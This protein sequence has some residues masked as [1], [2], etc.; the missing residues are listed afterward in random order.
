MPRI[1]NPSDTMSTHK[2]PTGPLD[3][4]T[5]CLS[6]NLSEPKTTIDNKILKLGGSV[7]ATVT[8]A[9]TH[10]ISTPF[11][12]EALTSKVMDVYVL[13]EALV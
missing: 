11:E 4:A 10:L 2:T 8:D 9:C 13:F 1:Y 6:G 7:E 3:G 5:I 12:L